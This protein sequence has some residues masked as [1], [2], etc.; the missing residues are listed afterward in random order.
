[1]AAGLDKILNSKDS[2]VP[3]IDALN[4]ITMEPDPTLVTSAETDMCALKAAIELIKILIAGN[5]L[6]MLND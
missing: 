5:Q 2:D 6:L 4:I 1:M 3:Q